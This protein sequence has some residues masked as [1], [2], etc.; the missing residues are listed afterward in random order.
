VEKEI[1]NN[2]ESYLDHF[3]ANTNYTNEQRISIFKSEFNLELSDRKIGSIINK[4][5]KT[6]ST[7]IGKKKT[8]VYQLADDY[9]GNT[10]ETITTEEESDEEYKN[11]MKT[12]DV[13]NQ[14]N[15]FLDKYDDKGI[16]AIPFI[17]E[18]EDGVMYSTD[19]I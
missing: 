5:F 14:R 11:R 9:A 1:E 4:Y 16:N 3:K 18:I 2:M 19:K 12:L 13:D 8:R 6:T 15:N 7:C 17:M 10:E